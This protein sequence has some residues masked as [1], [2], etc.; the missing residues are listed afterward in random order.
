[1]EIGVI[2]DVV[3][4][5][6]PNHVPTPALLEY[7]RF[8]ADHFES[9]ANAQSRQIAS[10]MQHGVIGGG[11]HVIFRVEPENHVDWARGRQNVSR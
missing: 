9:G 8:F 6:G 5:E 10:N 11:F 7:T 2:P 1:M 4:G 3:Q